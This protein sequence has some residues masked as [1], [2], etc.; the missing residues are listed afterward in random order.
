MTSNEE[1]RAAMGVPAWEKLEQRVVAHA[2]DV[3]MLGGSLQDTGGG[4]N[5]TGFVLHYPASVAHTI[6][7]E[8]IVRAGD[9]ARGLIRSGS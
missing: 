7:A 3:L 9:A 1:V 6:A 4:V 5:S 2:V 8:A